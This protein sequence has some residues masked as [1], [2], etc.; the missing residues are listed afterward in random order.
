MAGNGFGES[1]FHFG[2][3]DGTFGHLPI[4]GGGGGPATHEDL[5][6]KYGQLQLRW[7]FGQL[8]RH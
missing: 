4:S 2:E 7:D 5:L 6:F 1:G 8:V 3:I